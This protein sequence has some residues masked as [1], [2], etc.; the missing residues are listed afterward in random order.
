MIKDQIIE[1]IEKASGAKKVGLEF[2]ENDG[3]GDYS[4]NI[5]MVLAKEEDKNPR[6]LAEEIKAK[7]ESLPEL[8]E[9]ISRIEIAGP[10][11][12][13]FWLKK[14]VLVENLTDI[15]EKGESYG[16]SDVQKGKKLMFEFAHPNTHKAFHIGHLRNITT[17]ESLARLAEFTGAG[18][19][20]VNYQ[21]DVGLHIAKAVW[22]IKKLGFNDP[23][24]IRSRAEF[25][26]KAYA[27]GAA[28][29]EEDEAVKSEINDLNKKIYSKEDEEIN[30]LYEETRKWSLDY[31]ARIYERVYTKFDRLY[32][33]S[34]C[35]EN[36]KQIA[37]TALK[38]GILV[39]SEGAT[40]F[41]GTKFGLHD[42]VF[43]TGQ[44]T[45][46]YE[47]KEV[48]LARLQFEEYDPDTV[49]HIVGP[50]QSG[51]FQVIFK[52]L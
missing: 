14:E 42:R 3:F 21:G 43:I 26:G 6:K 5:A 15:E 19:I 39:K 49:L 4:T 28:A 34:E 48:E 27:T 17:G 52:A 24:E 50:E 44:E 12:I 20:R 18:V 16:K 38:K 33:E 29:Y 30:K 2:P 1:A 35:A 23:G 36:G 41:P 25:L 46:T 37:L 10:G 13:N 22:G 47:A 7:F 8:M 40:I 51:Y 45:P 9:I 32:F 11:F 31:F